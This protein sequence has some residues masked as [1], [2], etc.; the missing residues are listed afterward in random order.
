M[1]SASM[2]FK[3]NGDLP[4]LSLGSNPLSILLNIFA[5]RLAIIARVFLLGLR[6]MSCGGGISTCVEV[7]ESNV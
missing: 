1:S 6:K 4:N 7:G 3:L 2:M 5:G